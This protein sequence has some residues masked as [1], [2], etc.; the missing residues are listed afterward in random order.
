MQRVFVV[1][2]AVLTSATAYA[3]TGAQAVA[4]M[5]RRASWVAPGIQWTGEIRG[6]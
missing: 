4:D 5:E 3:Q 2:V 6:F 1:V